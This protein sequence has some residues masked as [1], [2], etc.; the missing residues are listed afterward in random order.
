MTVHHSNEIDVE[1]KDSLFHQTMDSASFGCA[2]IS[3]FPE[4]LKQGCSLPEPLELQI[5]SSIWSACTALMDQECIPSF[6]MLASF[7]CGESR[8]PLWLRLLPVC[9]FQLIFNSFA[10]SCTTS[11]MNSGLLSDPIVLG[12]PNQGMI[13]FRR[14]Q[15]TSHA[16]LCE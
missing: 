16:F 2:Q 4:Y 3:P 9:N 15:F 10:T 11:A 14:S 12:I 1:N 13:P 5:A 7:C 8:D 6:E